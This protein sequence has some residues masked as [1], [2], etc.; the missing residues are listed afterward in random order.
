[1]TDQVTE[2]VGETV[3]EPGPVG[4]IVVELPGTAAVVAHGVG[5]RTDRR[6][7]RREDRR[8]RRR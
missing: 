1:M 4:R 7:D 3:D 2:H 6:D 5:R 8:G